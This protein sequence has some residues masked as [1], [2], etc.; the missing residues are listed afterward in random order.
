MK[1]EATGTLSALGN[2]VGEIELDEAVYTR[3]NTYTN[4]RVHVDNIDGPVCV[5]QRVQFEL[6]VDDGTG[7]REARHVRP[8]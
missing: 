7:D 5:G 6:T 4:A 8:A 3:R 1:T 2:T